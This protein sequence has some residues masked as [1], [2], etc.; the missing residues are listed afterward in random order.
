MSFWRSAA[1]YVL[2][3]IFATA[4]VL[5]ITSYDIGNTIEKNSIKD[6]I[7]FEMGPSFIKEQCQN[8]CSQYQDK[9][10]CN[11][12][13]ISDLTNQTQ[14][15]IGKTLDEIYDK[16]LFGIT[17]NEFILFLNNYPMFAAIGIVAGILLLFASITPLS[18]L[19]KN[20]VTISVSLFISALIPYFMTA[21]VNLPLDLGGAMGN[22]FSSGF[23]QQIVFGIIF[24]AAGL[25]LILINYALDRRK[26]KKK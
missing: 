12:F 25:I 16:K 2:S 24:I 5:S 4:I 15:G 22:Y 21:S 19:G 8:K 6:F 1:S 26:S 14:L 9:E 13:C 17:L 10:E 11:Q 3:F 23:N 18:T 20:F 7:R